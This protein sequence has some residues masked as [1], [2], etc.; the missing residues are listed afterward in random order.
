MCQNAGIEPGSAVLGGGA[1]ILLLGVYLQGYNVIVAL[2]TTIYPVWR[3]ALTIE[4][5]NAEETKTWLCYWTVYGIVQIIEL[6]LGFV[7]S[8]VPYYA[9]IRLLFFIYLM[10]PNVTLT[11]GSKII[12]NSVFK[13]LLRQHKDSI[14]EFFDSLAEQT[15][16]VAGQAKDMAKKVDLNKIAQGVEAAQQMAADKKSD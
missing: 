6:L 15:E 3:T 1:A 9:V 14:N 8:Y 13:P 4:D 5:K 11:N 16:S 10:I 2:V 12:Y 7:L